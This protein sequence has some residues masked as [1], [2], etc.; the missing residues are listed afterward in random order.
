V[1]GV[2]LLN[3][4]LR[5][6]HVERM[7]GVQRALVGG[8]QSVLTGTPLGEAFF[9]SVATPTAVS[10]ILKQAYCDGSAV[11]D[12]LVD[13]ILQPGLQPGAAKVFLDF[14]SYSG[15]P[16]PE[17]LL[18]ALPRE[19]PCSYVHGAADPWEDVREARRLFKPVPTV[20]EWV[21]LDGVGHCPQDEAPGRVNALI[22]AFVA[23]HAAAATA[24]AAQA[25]SAAPA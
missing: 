15:G 12:E 23:R 13:A 6:M 5:G 16:L 2:Q 14:I 19:V 9:A 24:P 11:T 10:N 25:A 17:A 7:G 20:E 3:M 22:E 8:V 4:S 1:R 21:E 18:A